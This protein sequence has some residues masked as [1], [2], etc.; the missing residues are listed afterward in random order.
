MKIDTIYRQLLALLQSKLNISKTPIYERIKKLEKSGV[1]D[2][3]VAI[4]DR[5]KIVTPMV[6]FCS[7]SLDSQKLK[8]IN[9]FSSSIL[10]VPEVME[11]YLMSGSNDFLL[12]VVVKNLND[13][14]LFSSV[15][16]AAL[17]NVAQIK[18]T[19]VLD[20][21]KRATVLPIY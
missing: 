11:C 17:P 21:I 8:E 3:Y 16:L 9:D 13:Y 19:F 18:S 5:K 2:K 7:V 10:K 20:E 14:H 4:L 6:V 15:K 1:I 12:K